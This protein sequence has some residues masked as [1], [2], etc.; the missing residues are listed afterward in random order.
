MSLYLD[1]AQRKQVHQIRATWRGRSEWP[2][3]L[4]I[5]T[6]YGGWFGTA[7]N[8]RALGL[9]F[10]ACILAVLSCWYMSL[11]HELLHGHPTRFPIVNAAFGFAP[12]AVW[13]PYAVYR[14]SHLRHH[15]DV[16]LTDPHLD[17]ESYFVSADCWREAGPLMRRLL[18][19]RNTLIGRMVIG[20]WFSI[21]IA[22]RHAA[23]EIAGGNIRVAAQ[24]TAHLLAFGV[25]ALW[26]DRRCGITPAVFVLGIGYPA[27]AL[28]AIRSFQEHRAAADIAQRTVINEAALPWRLLFLNNNLHAVHHDLPGLPWFALPAVYGEKRDAYLVRNGGFVTRGYSEWASRYAFTPVAHPL[29]AGVDQAP[30]EDALQPAW[31]N[32]PSRLAS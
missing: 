20:P 28:G 10:A 15:D 3:W 6:I 25:L 32:D 12:L 18:I 4:L 29:R 14:E 9:P 31:T 5:A 26:L 2:T 7:L 21:L 16:N 17:P 8:A 11:Q 19:L 23:G 27:L 24:W 13:F 1:A 30:T 22:W